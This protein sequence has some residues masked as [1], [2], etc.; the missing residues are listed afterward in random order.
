M[1][2]DSQQRLCL[3]TGNYLRLVGLWLGGDTLP[4]EGDNLVVLGDIPAV[5]GHKE[6]GLLLQD[7]LA[8]GRIYQPC[9]WDAISLNKEKGK[10]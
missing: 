9:C 5:A 7:R 3:W 8:L 6:V 2:A 4:V 1:E 10:L